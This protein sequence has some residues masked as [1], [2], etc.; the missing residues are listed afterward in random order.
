[1][2]R[3]LVVEDDIEEGVVNRQAIVVVNSVPQLHS[4]GNGTLPFRNEVHSSPPA[5]AGLPMIRGE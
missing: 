2:K 5:Q 3:N 4:R 1:M